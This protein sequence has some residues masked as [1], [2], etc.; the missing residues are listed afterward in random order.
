ML[1]LWVQPVCSAVPLL[2]DR[3]TGWNAAENSYAQYLRSFS[4]SSSLHNCRLHSN[5]LPSPT[6]LLLQGVFYSHYGRQVVVALCAP[7]VH[8]H[9]LRFSIMQPISLA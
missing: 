4:T 2:A 3:M 5:Q 6:A 8:S 9:H 1:L 7:T